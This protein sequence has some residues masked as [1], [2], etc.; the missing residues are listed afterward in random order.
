MFDQF[1]DDDL[2]E[3]EDFEEFESRHESY[4]QQADLERYEFNKSLGVRTHQRIKN[5]F[6]PYYGQFLGV[7]RGRF[8]ELDRFPMD[9][10]EYHLEYYILKT[11]FKGFLMRL[12][13]RPILFVW[14]STL[15]DD[16]Q[17]YAAEERRA[18]QLAQAEEVR[19]KL[20]EEED[21]KKR[22]AIKA[23]QDARRE[24]EQEFYRLQEEARRRKKKAEQRKLEAQA[25]EA[26]KLAA[27]FPMWLRDWA[28][29]YYK[30]RD[31]DELGELVDWAIVVLNTANNKLEGKLTIKRI[32]KLLRNNA[33][34][35][36][37]FKTEKFYQRFAQLLAAQGY[38]EKKYG[39]V[40]NVIDPEALPYFEFLRAQYRAS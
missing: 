33:V 10:W 11:D 1:S 4:L 5:P 19:L 30:L 28:D 15:G 9:E 34:S 20:E 36:P 14:Y 37:S 31:Y 13:L 16:S 7:E 8:R 39:Q 40:G 18:Q 35:N 2:L 6:S 12:F 27:V 22:A 23:A 38:V 29:R 32:Y 17:F 26:A 3:L 25:R 24:K 21:R